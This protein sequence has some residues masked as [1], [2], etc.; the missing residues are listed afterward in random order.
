MLI[1]AANRSLTPYQSPGWST[2]APRGWVARGWPPHPVFPS[3][4]VR[5][6]EWS[7]LISVLV[8]SGRYNKTTIDLVGV[9]RALKQHLSFTALETG[10]PKIEAL[11]DSVSGESQLPGPQ[12]ACLLHVSSQGRKEEKG[13]L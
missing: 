7:H 6:Q 4:K 11:A 3:C 10:T 1:N 9:G 13:P 2:E 5:S 12:M 8:G